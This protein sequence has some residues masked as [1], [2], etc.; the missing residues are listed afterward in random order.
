MGDSDD[1][2]DRR[3]G[4]EK[5]RRERDV[6]ERR[7]DRRRDSRGDQWEM[8]R[9]QRKQSAGRARE[10]WTSRSRDRRDPYREYDSRH[11]D[12]G[13]SPPRRDISPP[14]KR[15][16]RD[17][18]QRDDSYHPY[19]VPGGYGRP[20][21]GG[22]PHP[23]A[24]GHGHEMA[25]GMPQ[26]GGAPFNP[27]Q[28]RF[29]IKYHPEECQKRK[30]DVQASLKNRCQ[31]FR[32][33]LQ[34]NRVEG[35]VC[36]YDKQDDIVKLLDAAVIKMEGGNDFDLT[37]LDQPEPEDPGS[38]SRNNSESQ[39]VSESPDEKR[40]KKEEKDKKPDEPLKLPISGEQKELMKKAR[41]FSKQQLAKNGSKVV[42]FTLFMYICNYKLQTDKKKKK[43][44]HREKTEYSY[45]SGSES[46]SESGSESEP[47]PAPPGLED[48]PPPPGVDDVPGMTTATENGAQEGESKEDVV[49]GGDEKDVD[50]KN[51]EEEEDKEK[52]PPKP[53]PLHKTCSIFLRNL[54]P[55]ITKQ[56]VEAM[57][58]KYPGFVRVA[59]QDPQPERQFFRRGW[60]TFSK[61]INIKEICWNLN[62]I[63]SGGYGLMSKNP[64][65]KN[66]TDYLVEEGSYEEEE[67]LGQSVEDGE[68]EGVDE[69]GVERD[70]K[71]LKVI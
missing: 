54:A 33:L 71:L 69:S 42:L 57:C 16:R 49:D 64:V 19:D 35:V 1:E 20:V 26:Q 51:E 11:R 18:W 53:R 21:P 17:D 6:Y 46:E 47:E 2:Y 12:R 45:E 3:K 27:G 44:R 38:R 70:E 7:D 43:N 58:K 62:N 25:G 23:H 14:S 5:F 28:S 37:V 65:L 63:R 30:E 67:L 66:I 9:M 10:A 41:E 68:K 34:A 56:E 39:S 60:V 50:T 52:G 29:K 61:E 32:E 55:S 48:E 8:D 24:W 31:V 15:M 4:R 22:A 13:Y 36:D 40:K 59:L